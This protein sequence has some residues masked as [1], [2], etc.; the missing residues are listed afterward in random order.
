MDGFHSDFGDAEKKK[1]S[2]TVSN[3]LI[4]WL[5]L[6]EGIIED[7]DLLSLNYAPLQTIPLKECF[8][9]SPHSVIFVGVLS[10]RVDTG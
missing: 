9:K 2:H 5:P 1:R 7:E 6:V 3:E 10:L 4:Y 8:K